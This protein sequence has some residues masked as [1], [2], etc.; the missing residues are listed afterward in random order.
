MLVPHPDRE[1]IS[2]DGGQRRQGYQTSYVQL[3]RNVAH[4]R[5]EKE[6]SLIYCFAYLW[7]Y[8]YRQN[9]QN[10]LDFAAFFFSSDGNSQ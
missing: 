2:L 1:M 8:A 10:P 3:V 5:F 4:L 7:F 9:P 6:L